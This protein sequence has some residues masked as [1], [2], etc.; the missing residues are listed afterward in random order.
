MLELLTRLGYTLSLSKCSLVPETCKKFL[1]FYV[2]SVRQAFILPD[3]KKLKFTELR[4]SILSS[5]M[6]D[7]KTLQRFCGKCISMSI[8]VPGCKLFCREVNSAI[9]LAIRNSRLVS[10]TG[11]LKEELEYWRFLDNWSG[12]SEW[13]PEFHNRVDMSTDSSGYRYGALVH[14]GKEKIVLSD[15]WGD[16]DERPIH[17]KEADA[18]LKSLQA[19]REV[20]LN[21]RVDVLC[22]NTAV[23]CAWNNQG[24]KCPALNKVLKAIFHCVVDQNIDLHLSYISS[25]QNVADEP[26]RQLN[27]AD[28]MLS[29]SSWLKV[30]ERFGPH[31]VDLM[32]LDSNVMVSK[33]GEPLRHFTPWPTPGTSGVNL[34]SQDLTK[35]DNLYVFPPLVLVFPLLCFLEEQKVSCTVVVPELYPVPVWW[36]KLKG[37]SVDYFCIGRKGEKGVVKVPSK[38]GF[39]LDGIGLRWSLFVFRVSFCPLK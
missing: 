10:V 19:L 27:F 36:P 28:T 5:K 39:I 17:V 20:L 35:E 26:S 2:D 8:A 37:A 14:A 16:F 21:S 22:D 1:G 6:V 13:R 9:S 23:V 18:I 12:F 34:F 24:C 3:D 30:E 32:S 15:Y 38:Q 33:E 4:D 25:C 31:S 29:A 11:A 7:L